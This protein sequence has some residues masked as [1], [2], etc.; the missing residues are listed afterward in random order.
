[1]C[2]YYLEMLTGI[3]AIIFIKHKVDSKLVK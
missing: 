3:L 2:H 1:M